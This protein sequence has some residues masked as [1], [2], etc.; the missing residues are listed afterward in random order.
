MSGV[1]ASRGD[2]HTDGHVALEHAATLVHGAP[3]LRRAKSL[4][5]LLE[6][7]VDL[8]WSLRDLGREGPGLV[9]CKL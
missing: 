6:L 4:A 2:I 8:G 9:C 1:V 7:G 3:D 5:L